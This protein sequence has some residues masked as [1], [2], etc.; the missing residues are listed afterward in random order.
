ME[1][2]SFFTLFLAPLTRRMSLWHF[3]PYKFPLLSSKGMVDVYLHNNGKITMSN[4]YPEFKELVHKHA[5]SLCA[6]K[7][8]CNCSVC[9]SI[10]KIALLVRNTLQA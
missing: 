4:T 2:R 6:Y 5:G 1:R 10:T 3:W 8:V 7:R 9:L